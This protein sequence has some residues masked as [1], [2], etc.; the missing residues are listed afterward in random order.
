MGMMGRRVDGARD[1]RA[2]M[3]RDRSAGLMGDWAKEVGMDVRVDGGGGVVKGV[4]EGALRSREP[5]KVARWLLGPGGLCRT[6]QGWRGLWVW[7]GEFVLW[8]DGRWEMVD[9]DT[10]TR[11]VW[12]AL[13]DARIEREGVAEDGTRMVMSVRLK[14]GRSLVEEVVAALRV[15]AELPTRVCDAMPVWI[16][17][18]G[19]G[20]EDAGWCVAFEDVVVD[21]RASARMGGWVTWPRDERWFGTVVVP[22]RWDSG[23]ACPVWERSLGEWSGGE[24]GWSEVLERVL[25]LWLMGWRE[26]GRWVM[27]AGKARGGK[28][29]VTRIGM[30][31]MGGRGVV[32]ARMSG[33][34]GPFGKDGLQ[35]A[36]VVVV[37]EV[38]DMGK[39]AG[40][41][42]AAL[43]KEVVGRDETAIERKYRSAW[44]GRLDALMVLVGNKIPVM[45]DDARGL[46]GKMV[47]IA[48]RYSWLGRENYGLEGQLAGELGGIARRVVEAGVRMARDADMC[49]AKVLEM[50]ASGRE[51]VRVFTDRNNQVVRYL[52]GRFVENPDGF[53]DAGWLRDDYERW[54]REAGLGLGCPGNRVVRMLVRES[55]WHLEE[56][57]RGK[58]RVRGVRGLSLRVV[59][60][61]DDED[62][63]PEMGP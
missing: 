17:N 3:R 19:D 57:R 25:C 14:P 42:V 20:P 4:D 48:F 8:R 61:D 29:T 63:G 12:L 1:W 13:E 43:V 50:T 24:D 49:P 11:L 55:P 46:S 27:L 59:A 34:A 47:A 40:E 5:L 32:T 10:V 44:R 21:L 41:E 31:L 54:C 23:A 28:G 16:G 9:E 52:E 58:E 60:E 35:H 37:N 30:K 56:V 53:V 18:E 6:P 45:P 15:V 62:D 26:F 7:R 39:G 2:E 38:R 22:C 36:R 51:A 33:L